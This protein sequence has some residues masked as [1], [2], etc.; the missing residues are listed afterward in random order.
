M[1]I[2]VY[3]AIAVQ[4][5]ITTLAWPGL[6]GH[7]GTAACAAMPADQ[8]Q[9]NP[10]KYISIL[11]Y[12]AIAADLAVFSIALCIRSSANVPMPL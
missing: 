9:G 1:A 6:T 8:A 4:V 5:S 2:A 7:R 11:A 3:V 12:V 10:V